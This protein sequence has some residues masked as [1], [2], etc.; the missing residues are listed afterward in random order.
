[1][2]T[3]EGL[4]GENEAAEDRV[5]LSLSLKLFHEITIIRW[6]LIVLNG[7]HYRYI[8]DKIM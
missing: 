3:G 5:W 2:V 8:N 1:M 4:R 6:V 7:L